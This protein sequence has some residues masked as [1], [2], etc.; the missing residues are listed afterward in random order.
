MTS[1]V[2]YR[3]WRPQLLSDVVGQEHVT[4]TLANALA[5]QRVAHAYLFSGPRGTGK[6]STGRILAK[7][8]NC[9]RDGKGEPCNECAMCLAM[10]EGRA[11]DLIEIDAASNRGI[12]EI[13]ELRERVKY[14][15]HQARFKVYIIDE[16]HM[17]TDAAFNALLKTLEEPPPQV[18][19]ILATTEP[20]RIPATI[21]SRCQRFDFRRIPSSA[22]VARLS[23]ICREEGVTIDDSSLAL[24]ARSAAGSLRDASN[25]LE[26]LVVYYGHRIDLHQVRETLGITGDARIRELARN[27][28][29]K[30]TAGGLDTINSMTKDGLDP[31]Q[32]QR[33]LME[34]LRAALLVGAGAEEA[35]DLALDEIA[36]MKALLAR[37][38]PQD[39]AKAIRLVSRG[40]LR[41]EGNSTLPLELA[42]V[43]YAAADPPLK[44]TGVLPKTA[45]ADSKPALPQQ[46]SIRETAV[47]EKV[48][49][50]P[51][52]TKEELAPVEAKSPSV[53]TSPSL[54]KLKDN[55]RQI[56]N[57]APAAYRRSNAQALLRSSCEPVGIEDQT[58]VLGFQHSIHKENMEKLEN[59]KIAEEILSQALG[60]PYKVR[61]VLL[62]PDKKPKATGP[63][64]NPMVEAALDMGA[65]IIDPE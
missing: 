5:T 62:P 46:S 47:S 21:H 1:Q 17:L 34:Y 43:E 42:L 20:H 61:C 9:L 58:V 37:I 18:I 19:F 40:D 22:V 41:F 28:L 50:S 56:I 63:A 54:E 59:R 6:T 23:H 13:R 60:S 25:V 35:A 31:R 10:S 26:Q 30:D 11:M 4:R 49:P 15:P 52:E 29:Q 65:R 16:V 53:A 51:P 2:F 39:I 27:L 24:I 8:I 44:D 38:P 33:E 36:D 12:D 45:P 48:I 3:K 64:Q 32:V 57:D 7:A 14:A 55:W